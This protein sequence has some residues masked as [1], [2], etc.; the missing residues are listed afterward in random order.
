[1]VHVGVDLHK[2]MSQIA[3][4][5]ADGEA[6]QHLLPLNHLMYRKFKRLGSGSNF[7]TSVSLLPRSMWHKSYLD[8]KASGVSPCVVVR[9]SVPPL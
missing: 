2:R 6:T 5:T 3:V 1:M 8:N 7:R 9:F 4:L